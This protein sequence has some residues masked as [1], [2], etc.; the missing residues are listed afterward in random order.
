MYYRLGKTQLLGSYTHFINIFYNLKINVYLLLNWYD[1]ISSF[2]KNRSHHVKV[3]LKVS[4]FHS[5]TPAMGNF[6]PKG[7]KQQEH[8]NKLVQLKVVKLAGYN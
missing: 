8:Q 3:E 5:S 7:Y 2:S 4:H 6:N 1:T